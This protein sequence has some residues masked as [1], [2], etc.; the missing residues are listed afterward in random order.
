MEHYTK[1][2]SDLIDNRNTLERLYGQHAILFFVFLYLDTNSM[3]TAKLLEGLLYGE[4]GILNIPYMIYDD[5]FNYVVAVPS[6]LL[7][8]Y[9]ML[10]SQF[11]VFL[12]LSLLGIWD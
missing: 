12:P 3:L 2:A 5:T 6:L 7:M 1:H 10:G 4:I 8:Q 11:K 9:F